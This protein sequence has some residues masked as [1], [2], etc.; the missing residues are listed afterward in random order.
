MCLIHG[1]KKLE[2]GQIDVIY[3]DFTTAFDKVPHCRLINKLL[4]YGINDQLI[5]WINDFLLHRSQRVKISAWH[6]VISGISQ[7]SVLGPLLFVIFIND[8]PDTCSNFAAIFLFADDSIL[9]KHVRSAEDSV[10]LQRSCFTTRGNPLKLCTYH[11]K[12]DLCKYNFMV[13]VISLWNSLPTQVFTVVSVDSFNNRL[14]KF[15]ANEEA[16]FDYKA[17]LSGSSFARC[18]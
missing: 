9:F 11:P 14:D 2:G 1:L 8:L 13:T 16:C 15:W 3:T 5:L 17:N 10:V 12:Y 4:S 6:S 18:F 7:G